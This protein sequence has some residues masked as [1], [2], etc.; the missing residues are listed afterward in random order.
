VAWR[1]AII[2]QNPRTLAPLVEGI[3]AAGHEPVGLLCLSR[4]IGSAADAEFAEAARTLVTDAPPELD[5]IV[6]ASRPRIAPLLAALEPELALCVIFP[7]KIPP[8]G[9][10]VPA[11][12]IV[13]CHLGLLPNDRGPLGGAWAIRRGERE[14]GVTWHRMDERFDTGPILAQGSFP[15]EDEDDREA[16]RRKARETLMGLLPRVFER[17]AAGD[18]GDPQADGTYR[19][20]FEEEYAWIDPARPAREVH[21]QVRAWWFGLG[22]GTQGPLI[23]LDG[24]TVRVLRTSLTE[25]DARRLECGDGPLWILE[26]EPLEDAG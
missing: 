3:R 17:L 23:E 24:E 8:E 18:A 19:G 22:E 12:G 9:L 26:T 13:N 21:N 11:R 5:V 6:P 25:C 2:S 1:V 4:G 15:I 20:L 14:F 10:A 7:W 16:F